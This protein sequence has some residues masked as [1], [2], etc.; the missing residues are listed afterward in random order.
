MNRLGPLTSG[1]R[2]VRNTRS[3]YKGAVRKP[4]IYGVETMGSVPFRRLCICRDNWQVGDVGSRKREESL[5]DVPMM[6]KEGSI[7][8]LEKM[9]K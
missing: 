9:A 8:K 6:Q 1:R 2:G 3:A 7:N 5:S 4:G